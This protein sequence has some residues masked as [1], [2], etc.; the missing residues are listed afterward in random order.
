MSPLYPQSAV[1]VLPLQITGTARM[2]QIYPAF[3]YHLIIISLLCV[4]MRIVEEAIIRDMPW[5]MS[6][7]PC[8]S[9]QG[10]IFRFYH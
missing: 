9:C 1:Y 2:S 7:M 5:I 8:I 6:D 10:N 4:E 3:S